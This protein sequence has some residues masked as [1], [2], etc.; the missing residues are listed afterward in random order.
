MTNLLML[1]VYLLVLDFYIRML[2][3]VFF[4]SLMSGDVGG[5]VGLTKQS[6]F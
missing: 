5:C 3:W 6:A 2:G 4:P 1:E